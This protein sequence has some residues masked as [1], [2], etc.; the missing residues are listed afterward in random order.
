M[1]SVPGAA[2]PGAGF[3][4][5]TYNTV[6]HQVAEVPNAIAKALA[7]AST[8]PEK[9][10]FFTSEQ[11]ADA[12]MQSQ[13][14]GADTSHSP[15]QAGANAVSAAGQAAAGAVSAA[16]AVPDFLGRLSNPHTWLRVAE[17]AVGV[18]LLAVGL[19]ALLKQSTGVDVA[20]TVRKAVR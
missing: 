5:W 14:G 6:S 17:V 7:I 16:S 9:L 8:W 18:I 15:I 19:N 1:A 4:Q 20:G 10:I 2:G 11:A 13:G 3:P 12:Y